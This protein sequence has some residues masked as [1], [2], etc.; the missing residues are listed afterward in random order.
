V[1]V[2]N[3]ITNPRRDSSSESKSVE[4]FFTLLFYCEKIDIHM[5]L[6]N[7]VFLQITKYFELVLG[8]RPQLKF[9]CSEKFSLMF[10]IHINTC[11]HR[12]I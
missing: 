7:L 9:K 6:L 5:F 12:L 3:K 1:F 2:V 10:L 8:Y 11:M 4:D